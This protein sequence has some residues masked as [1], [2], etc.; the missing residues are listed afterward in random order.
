M[1]ES[2]LKL[3][4]RAVKRAINSLRKDKRVE[5]INLGAIANES[6]LQGR[7]IG[8][9]Q[10]FDTFSLVDLPKGMPDDIFKSLK[11]LKVMNKELKIHRQP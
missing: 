3:K 8:R 10:I 2:P 7:K 1:V 6:G 5:A 9:I 4:D 11:R